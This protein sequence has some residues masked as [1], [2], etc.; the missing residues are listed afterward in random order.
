MQGTA[1]IRT[2]RRSVL[3]FLVRPLM[4][5]REAFTER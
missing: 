4:K 1:Q 3:S 5:S 2:G